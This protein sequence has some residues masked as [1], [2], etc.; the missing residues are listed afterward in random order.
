[1]NDGRRQIGGEGGVRCGGSQ[2]VDRG[3]VGSVPISKIVRHVPRLF[4]MFQDD[5]RG[6]LISVLQIADSRCRPGRS[7][8]ARFCVKL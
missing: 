1:M 2:H 5:R 8:L 3:D 4:V 6:E 7:R